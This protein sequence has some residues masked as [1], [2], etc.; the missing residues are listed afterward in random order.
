MHIHRNAHRRSFTVVSNSALQDRTLSFNAR[1]LLAH[2]LSRRDGDTVNCRTLAADGPTGRDAIKSGLRELAARGYYRVTR[3]QD[4][5]TGRVRSTSHVYE[6]PYVPEAPEPDTPEPEVREAVFP[7]TEKPVPGNTG[8]TRTGESTSEEVPTTLPGGA[9]EPEQ[10][11]EPRKPSPATPE[12]LAALHLIATAD[13]RLTLGSRDRAALA[14]LVEDWLARGATEAQ[15][16]AAA[17]QGLPAAVRN[18]AALLTYRLQDKLPPLPQQ[19]PPRAVPLAQHP[20]C[21]DCDRPLAGAHAPADG[22][23]GQCRH[24]QKQSHLLADHR[25]L[26]PA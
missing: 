21:T 25:A 9:S 6:T 7:T 26:C 5:G 10:R 18:P 22:L 13:P 19:L 16:I 15:L 17:T 11:P 1:G 20:E 23:C 12:A 4:P 3:V 2:L 8:I 14:P 24:E